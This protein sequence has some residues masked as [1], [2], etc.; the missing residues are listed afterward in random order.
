[1]LSAIAAHPFVVFPAEGLAGLACE[2]VG[3]INIMEPVLRAIALRARTLPILVPRQPAAEEPV[4]DLGETMPKTVLG[5]AMI[6][7]L[8]PGE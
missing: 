4:K 8:S 6:H 2:V 7:G 3:G 1:M 5:G